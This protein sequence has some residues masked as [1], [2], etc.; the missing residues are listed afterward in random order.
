VA[1]TVFA[2]W[3]N[4]AGTPVGVVGNALGGSCGCDTGRGLDD[5]CLNNC[6][7]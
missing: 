5:F 6:I 2:R 7:R 1:G 4:G 3:N